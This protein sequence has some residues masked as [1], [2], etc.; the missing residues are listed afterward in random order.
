MISRGTD[1]KHGSVVSIGEP[2]AVQSWPFKEPEKSSSWAD[3]ADRE[4]EAAD[5]ELARI[6]E[7][8]E[9][10][11]LP[12]EAKL[13]EKLAAELAKPTHQRDEDLIKAQKRELEIRAEMSPPGKLG[14]P[15]KLEEARWRWLISD[16][17]FERQ[18]QFRRIHVYQVSLLASLGK[19]SDD[20]FAGSTIQRPELSKRL[21]EESCHMG[22]VISAGLAAMDELAS[23]GTELGNLVGFIR[24]APMRHTYSVGEHGASYYL[25]LN[26]GDITCDETLGK[27]LIAGERRIEDVG[28]EE[29][30]CHV[31]AGAKR[32]MG[33]F[34]S[35]HW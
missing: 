15:P 8:R 26:A 12:V 2:E 4:K 25:V 31:M 20:Y 17:A 21:D 34:Q 30:Y 5:A 7:K 16:R 19:D 24:N 14:L 22:I 9:R 10:R 6:R 27:E 32:K 18:A 23:H 11:G 3:T 29:R 13:P 28:G 35:E 1:F 33:V